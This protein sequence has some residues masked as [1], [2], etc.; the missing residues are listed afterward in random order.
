VTFDPPPAASPA[1]SQPLD[2]TA[3]GLGTGVASQ[4]SINGD[5]PS[6]QRIA[7]VAPDRAPW[8]RI[9]LIAAGALLVVAILLLSVRRRRR[10]ARPALS[11]LERAL[12]RARREPAPGTTLHALEVGF[13][14]TPA[15]AAYVRALRENRYRDLPT[16]PSRA[17]RRG[18]RS[19]LGRGGG[20]RGR[21]LAW[22][23]VPPR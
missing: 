5:L 12:R 15:A 23:A 20:I 17:Q 4:Q 3:P 22:W 18:L 9:P 21:I 11:E 1:R 7:P 8:W 2:R 6:G 16:H 13:A 10:G 19:E 14:A